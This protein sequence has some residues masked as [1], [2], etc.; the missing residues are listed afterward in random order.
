ME[1]LAILGS[2][3]IG[4]GVLLLGVAAIWLVAVYSEKKE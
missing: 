2:F 3:F 4:V 1:F